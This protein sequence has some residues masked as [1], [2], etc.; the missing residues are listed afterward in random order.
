MENLP[1]NIKNKIDNLQDGQSI[2][3]GRDDINPSNDW[4]SHE[5]LIIRKENGQLII[6]DTSTNGTLIMDKE[7]L[8]A[9]KSIQNMKLQNR[10]LNTPEY[11]ALEKQFLQNTDYDYITLNKL[12]SKLDT[13]SHE[14]H[15]IM[16]YTTAN[17]KQILEQFVESG[18]K[19]SSTFRTKD[20]TSKDLSLLM[21][22]NRNNTNVIDL[23][24]NPKNIDKFLDK[25]KQELAKLREVHGKNLIIE[26]GYS[27]DVNNKE[28]A[29]AIEFGYTDFKGTNVKVSAVDN[30]LDDIENL[31]H[32]KDYIQKFDKNTPLDKMFQSTQT[33]DV[34]SI[35]GTMFVNDGEKMVQL[36]LKEDSFRELFPP[37]Q[38]F[39]IHQGGV[40][41]CYLDTS[42]NLLANSKKGRAKIYQMIGE[43]YQ[44]GKKVYYTTTHNGKGKKTYFERFT[45]HGNHLLDRNGL[46]IIEQGYCKNSGRIAT[47][48][49][50][51]ETQIMLANEY[52]YG[53]EALD[54]LTGDKAIIIMDK[55]KMEEKIKSLAG[56]D[57]VFIYGGTRDIN[58]QGHDKYL[59]HDYDLAQTHAYSIKGYDKGTN[60][61]LISNPWHS[62][63]EIK[64][65]MEE[66]LKQF[67][68][69]MIAQII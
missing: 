59:N 6:K 34:A 62:G 3:I 46:A 69:I 66:F 37:V 21:T 50:P 16:K 27:W 39:S 30:V 67:N 12:M 33:G 45:R 32:G 40:G 23:I 17:N 5:H 60:S 1:P 35:N 8:E 64:V 58:G 63:V 9:Y 13:S 44:N 15:N 20:I 54:G 41:T 68:N 22:F 19:K 65:P 24:S 48:W 43:E 49:K 26:T 36:A 47:E 4:I 31:I 57:D 2:K 14:F 10:N 28:I 56:R 55:N 52:G 53:D 25:S 51:G 42:I 11:A 7:G 29:D 18:I 61:V 38:R